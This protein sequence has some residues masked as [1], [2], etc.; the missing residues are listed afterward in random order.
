MRPLSPLCVDLDGTLVCADTLHQSLLAWVKVNPMR[1]LMALFSIRKGKARFKQVVANGAPFDA[2]ALPYRQDLLAWLRSERASGRRLILATGADSKI[3][4]AVSRHLGL[5]EAV[6]ASD[7][8]INMTGERKA[9]EI[10]R[11]LDNAPFLYAGDSRSDMKI[12]ALSEAAIV[13]D[14]YPRRLTALQQAGI[15]VMRTFAVGSHAIFRPRI[16][17]PVA[18]GLG[19]ALLLF[20]LLR[21]STA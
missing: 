1:A 18:F 16:I 3:A 8:R 5:F 17:F 15:P 9:R 6:I 20:L 14:P 13:M 12:W 19:A 11:Y 2:A 21:G 4:N 10:R 7:G